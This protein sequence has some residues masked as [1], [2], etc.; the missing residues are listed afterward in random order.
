[1]YRSSLLIIFLLI[2]G[3]SL[4]AD[5]KIEITQEQLQQQLVK[6]MPLKQE[7]M[8]VTVTLSSPVLELGIDG[9]KVGIF[10]NLDVIAPGGIKGTGRAKIVGTISYKKETGDFFLYKPTIAQI[11]IDQIP[12]EF[13]SNVK[14]LA[15]YALDSSIKNKPIFT[16]NDDNTQQ[17]MAKSILKSV[18][19][20][21]GKLLV[22]VAVTGN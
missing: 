4:G 20:Q 21:P 16:L 9:N 6:M 10:S 12:A 7:K 14:Q 18:E 8:F 1:M 22:T 2:S 15:Q 5:Y 17:K 19:V 3:I 11:E 13:H